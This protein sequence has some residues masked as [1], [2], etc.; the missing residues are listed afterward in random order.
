M[1][2]EEKIRCQVRRQG[3]SAIYCGSTF[4]T[5]CARGHQVNK[6]QIFKKISGGLVDDLTKSMSVITYQ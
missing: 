5:Q 1:S 3:S 6:D 4:H 2:F